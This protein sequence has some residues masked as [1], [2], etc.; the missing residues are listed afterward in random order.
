MLV[1][2][3]PDGRRPRHEVL[4][5]L[6]NGSNA[7]EIARVRRDHPGEPDSVMNG[8]VLGTIAPFRCEWSFS[9]VSVL[10]RATPLPS[11]MIDGWMTFRHRRCSIQAT[12]H[13]HPT[14]ALQL[15]PRRGRPN[16]LGDLPLPESNA[17]VHFFR[18]RCRPPTTRPPLSPHTRH[19]RSQ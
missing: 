9:P 8:R 3:D 2:P 18:A 12:G 7:A 13:L 15:I 16:A 4:N 10:P 14:R 5:V 17:A 1:T 11:P 6:H 19:G